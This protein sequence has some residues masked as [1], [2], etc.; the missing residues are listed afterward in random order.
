M[1]A[2]QLVGDRAVV[3]VVDPAD[4]HRFVA[5]QVQLGAVSGDRVAVL[6]GLTAGEEIVIEGSFFVRA[7]MDKE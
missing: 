2:V 6:S 1:R 7:E 5:R 4:R 3:Y